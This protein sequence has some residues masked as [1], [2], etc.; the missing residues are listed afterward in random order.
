M[1]KTTTAN[2]SRTAAP[3]KPA[4]KAK[5]QKKAKK[6]APTLKGTKRDEAHAW[7]EEMLGG[8][9]LGNKARTRRVVAVGAD[10][11]RSI[12]ASPAKAAAKDKGGNAAVCVEGASR[13]LN[14][15]F[16]HPDAIGEAGFAASAKR[17]V[18]VATLL[19]IQDTTSLSYNAAPKHWAT[20]GAQKTPRREAFSSIRR[21]SWT[22]ARARPWA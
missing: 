16:I 20:W 11:A 5:A 6:K 10:L 17:A 22:P 21:C 19:A 9:K 4:A 13:A 14:N 2:R 18:S 1:A 3:A 12:G 8:A 15:Q 7:A